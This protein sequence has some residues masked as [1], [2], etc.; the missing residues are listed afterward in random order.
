[1][2]AHSHPGGQA[3]AQPAASPASEGVGSGAAA[4]QNS[5]EEKE[6]KVEKLSPDEAQQLLQSIDEIFK[7]A[8]ADSALPI[9]SSVK[10]ELINRDQVAK[11]VQERFDEDEDAK[12]LQ[13]SE[14]VLKKF[15]LLP[16]DFHLRPFLIKLLREQVAGFYDFKKK[17]V[18]LLDWIQPDEQRPVMAHELTHALQDQNFDLDKW[19][20]QKKTDLGKDATS[21]DG[22]I[23][24]DEDSTA[25]GALVEGQG[26]AVLVDYELAPSKKTLLDAP[27]VVTAMK[28]SM[29]QAGD[30]PIFDSSPLLLRESLIFPYRDG[31]GFVQALLQSG[32]KEQAFAKALQ[33]PPE[34]TF[35]ILNPRDYLKG[36]H[37]PALRLPDMKALMGKEYDR[38]DVGAVGQFDVDI[39]LRQFEQKSDIAKAWRG[40][41]YY[42]AQRQSQKR[43]ESID[44][45]KLLYLSRW[46]S[47]E[48]AKQFARLYAAALKKKYAS[49]QE[50]PDA[51]SPELHLGT[52]QGPVYL[53]VK[54]EYV[55]VSEGFDDKLALKLRAAVLDQKQQ[56]V[57]VA[58]GELGWRVA[59]PLS[60]MGLM[61]Q[62]LLGLRGSTARLHQR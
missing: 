20:D 19:T 6:Q 35:D 57:E 31:L 16:P 58:Q 2:H 9:K 41:A 12:R 50:L 3:N 4:N 54:D 37:V 11:Y 45:L 52:H 59:A 38:Y 62:A 18:F 25:R 61:K 32:G 1:M 22:E 17:T 47:P 49:N 30:S 34:D 15:G 51:V 28:N 5:E 27:E 39:L 55:A 60:R 13:R 10:R 23:L 33:N 56:T 43:S 29:A 40:G 42:S 36:E 24:L 8:S 46:R 53:W 14:L 48:D 7:F 26:M 44:S 21:D